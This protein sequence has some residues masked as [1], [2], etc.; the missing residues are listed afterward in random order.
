MYSRTEKPIVSG[1]SRPMPRHDPLPLYVTVGYGNF[2]TELLFTYPTPLN[3]G[4][5]K[6]ARR[7]CCCYMN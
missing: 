2:N 5:T 7:C 6:A 4:M 3:A 1:D